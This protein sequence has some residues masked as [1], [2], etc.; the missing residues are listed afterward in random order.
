MLEFL[1][2]LAVSLTT[3]QYKGPFRLVPLMKLYCFIL[4]IL[5]FKMGLLDYTCYNPFD[6]SSNRL[7]DFGPH[8]AASVLARNGEAPHAYNFAKLQ[9]VGETVTGQKITRFAWSYP[10]TFL[11]I[12]APLSFLPY[13]FSLIIW[14]FITCAGYLFILYRIAPDRL[15]FWL[16]I[17]FPATVVNLNHGQNGFLFAALLGG[18]LLL[19]N[20]RPLVAGILLGL[21][22]CKPQFA[23]L[24]PI[25]LVG[26]RRWS[27]LGSMI[28][29]IMV[30]IGLSVIFFGWETWMA[31]F[32]NA[33]LAKEW[34]EIGVV[35]WFKMPTPFVSARMAGLSINVSYTLQA[36]VTMGMTG[37]GY[38]VC[39]QRK[40]PEVSNSILVLTILLATPH[41][42]VYDLTILAIPIA[43]LSWQGHIKGWLPFEKIILAVVW[44]MPL[45]SMFIALFTHLQI[46]PIILIMCL[47]YALWRMSRVESV[48]TDC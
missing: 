30:M 38:Y 23:I 43:Y 28:V 4:I 45:F 35:P 14:L 20:Q 2:R 31:F 9:P 36:L 19:L 37:I 29:T 18:A 24:L 1:N 22:T 7:C 10:P 40:E 15:T 16:A 48:R 26:G 6:K 47:I 34:L 41:A 33:L 44:H 13:S 21:F 27:V 12:V 32:Q 5:Y 46:G 3:Y 11:L 25:A 42:F 8:Y 39:S 17:A